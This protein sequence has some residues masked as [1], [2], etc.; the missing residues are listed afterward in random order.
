MK[1]LAIPRAFM[2]NAALLGIVLIP[3]AVHAQAKSFLLRV[4][5][6]ALYSH[7]DYGPDQRSSP[8]G[9]PSDSRAEVDIP[10]VALELKYFFQDDLYIETEIEFEH[11]GAGSALEL[12]YEEFG[13]FEFESEKGGEVEL[14]EFQITK[15]FSPAFNARMGHFLVAVGLVNKAGTPTQYFANVRPISETTLLP[16]AW[17]ETGAEVFGTVKSFAY[18]AQVVNGL[19]GTG[20]SSAN[21]IKGGMQQKFENVR[22]TDLAYVGRVDY[23]GVEGVMVGAS[24]YYGNTTGDRP[25]PDMA[26]IPAYVTIGDVHAAVQHRALTV[27]GCFMYGTLENADLVSQYNANLPRT[28]QVPRTPVA[29]A[30]TFYYG[31]IG[32]DLLSLLNPGS[33]HK[34]YPFARYD[35]YNSME[36]TDA[37][38][39]PVPRFERKVVT[40]GLNYFLTPNVVL[41][42]DYSRRTFGDPNVNDENT[43]SLGF[44]IVGGLFHHQPESSHEELR[45]EDED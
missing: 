9:A 24:I 20:F 11:G 26:G 43:V 3:C 34:L 40:G 1:N 16:N 12:E 31:E 2:R 36:N 37:G 7:Y 5:G 18:R 45:E 17:H 27:R 39:F 4:Y 32:Y 41:K 38:V 28:L 6:N 13:E 35:Y 29:S 44:G 42:A 15:S 21:W 19:D 25:K 8:T 33:T 30:A 14:E 23:V 10:R 22:A